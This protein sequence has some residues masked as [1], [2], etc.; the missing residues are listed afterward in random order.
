MS[1]H[2]GILYH[3]SPRRCRASILRRGLE[4]ARSSRTVESTAF[5]WVCLAT[6]PSS[7]WGLVLDPEAED[8]GWDLWQARVQDGDHVAIRGDF[9]PYV[10]EVRVHHGLPADRVWWVGERQLHAHET[11]PVEDGR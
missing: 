3:W 4:I 2:L 1:V 10:V 11:M 5:P 7:A 6:T 8:D 9:A